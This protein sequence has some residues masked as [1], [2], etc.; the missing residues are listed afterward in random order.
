LVSGYSVE[1]RARIIDRWQ[2]LE[3]MARDPSFLSHAERIFSKILPD[4][5]DNQK[6]ELKKRIAE[7]DM[8]RHALFCFMVPEL[9][10]TSMERTKN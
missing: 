2:I 9:R 10:K 7:I 6:N 1:L 4:N 5:L 3:D 8:V